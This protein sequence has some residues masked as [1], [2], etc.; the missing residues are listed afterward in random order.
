MYR[1][2]CFPRFRALDRA[3][4][5]PPGLAETCLKKLSQNFLDYDTPMLLKKLKPTQ[6]KTLSGWEGVCVTVLFCFFAKPSLL[7]FCPPI[8]NRT[9]RAKSTAFSAFGF[10]YENRRRRSVAVSKQ[11]T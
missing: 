10:Q 4:V 7:R 3:K 9:V 5:F 1:G 6:L 2:R 11:R 8:F